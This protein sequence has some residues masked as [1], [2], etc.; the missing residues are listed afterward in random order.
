LQADSPCAPGNHPDGMDCGTIGALGVECG[1]VKAKAVTWG[2]V[3]ALY[4]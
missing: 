2:S 4:R 1:T 3:K